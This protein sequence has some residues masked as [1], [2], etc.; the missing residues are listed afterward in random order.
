MDAVSKAEA[1]VW[2]Q[3]G[4]EVGGKF[5]GRGGEVSKNLQCSLAGGEFR[6]R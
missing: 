5:P 3:E 4:G 6:N 1:I 2:R